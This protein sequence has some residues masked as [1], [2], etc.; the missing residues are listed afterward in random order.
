MIKHLAPRLIKC[1]TPLIISTTTGRSLFSVMR[2]R[3]AR[4]RARLRCGAAGRRAGGG[5][6]LNTGWEMNRAVE[7]SEE[8]EVVV[9]W[10]FPCLGSLAWRWS[11]NVRVSV[12]R[13]WRRNSERKLLCREW[14]GSPMACVERCGAGGGEMKCTRDTS[15]EAISAKWYRCGSSLR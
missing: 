14:P 13:W 4:L 2:V 15:R 10:D 6:A 1:R 7:A 11:G 8:G 9:V 12:P 3:C 5:A